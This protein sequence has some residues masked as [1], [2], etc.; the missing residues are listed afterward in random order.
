M[1][2]GR[3]ET[4]RATSSYIAGGTIVANTFVTLESDG[5]VLQ[6]TDGAECKGVALCGGAAGAV[7]EVALQ[8]AGNIVRVI[9]G[10]TVAQGA[11][12]ASNATGRVID[13]ATGDIEQGQADEGAATAGYAIIHLVRGITTA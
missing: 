2:L 1:G 11:Q 6:A 12:V 10:A 13:S 3:K 9:A 7:I 5:E 8:N 4:I